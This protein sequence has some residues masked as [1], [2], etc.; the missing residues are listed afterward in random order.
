MTPEEILKV[1]CNDPRILMQIT[2]D[3]TG[4]FEKVRNLSGGH[5]LLVDYPQNLSYIDGNFY[6]H[7]DSKKRH[8]LDISSSSSILGCYLKAHIYGILHGPEEFSEAYVVSKY[9]HADVK[10]L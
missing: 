9:F 10:R 7:S 5:Y 3:A 2:L 4:D 1:V 8:I 6:I